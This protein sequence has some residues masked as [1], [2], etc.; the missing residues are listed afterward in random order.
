MPRHPCGN[1]PSQPAVIDGI[2]PYHTA[3]RRAGE[4]ASHRSPTRLPA[5]PPRGLRNRMRRRVVSALASP[6]IGNG[7]NLR[8]IPLLQPQPTNSE[9][10]SLVR[11]SSTPGARRDLGHAGA[12]RMNRSTEIAHSRRMIAAIRPAQASSSPNLDMPK[13]PSA[14]SH[15]RPRQGGR[16]H[17]STAAAWQRCRRSRPKPGALHSQRPDFPDLGPRAP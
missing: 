10:P 4:G 7:R 11:S 17:F 15:G 6:C 5:T 3:A 1:P 9:S 12:M 14:L 2:K 16:H 8:E 13:T